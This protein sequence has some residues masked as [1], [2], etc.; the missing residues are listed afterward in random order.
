MKKNQ[1]LINLLV[2]KEVSENSME[3]YARGC[4]IHSQLCDSIKE[5]L[6]KKELTA[7][8]KSRLESE[9]DKTQW[10]ARI[11][12]TNYRSTNRE[13][14]F[15]LIPAIEKLASEKD[16]KTI[17]FIKYK[18]EADELAKHEIYGKAVKEPAN[19]EHL[20]IITSI[21]KL[22][23]ILEKNIYGCKKEIEEN[24]LGRYEIAKL[25]LELYN[26]EIHLITLTKRLRNRENY[27]Y[28]QFLPVYVVEL[29]EAKEKIDIYYERGCEIAEKGI[30][31]QLPFLLQKYEEHKNNEERIW[32]YFTALK[33]R[34]NSLIDEINSDKIKYKEIINLARPI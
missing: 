10:E 31:P 26:N 13:Y 27:Y 11:F 2:K 28:N 7:L 6:L 24:K 14:Q 21:K 15:N 16:K 33:S 23:E 3:K 12:A 17:K 4:T 25:N 1:E 19:I 30:D 22:L 9:L 34:V 5:E 32:L 8:S 29:A 18:D 20:E